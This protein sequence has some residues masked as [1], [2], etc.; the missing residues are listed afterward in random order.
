MYQD[1][2]FITERKEE[3]TL[4][5]NL[6]NKEE[7][8]VRNGTRDILPTENNTITIYLY[9]PKL[10]VVVVVVER[11]FIFS[12]YLTHSSEEKSKW[13]HN[14]GDDRCDCVVYLYLMVRLFIIL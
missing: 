5:L 7:N 8:A 1:Y 2:L 11:P 14:Q 3:R 6:Y 13:G 12:M 10:A 9:P 4:K